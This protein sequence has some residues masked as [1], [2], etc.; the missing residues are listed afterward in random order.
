MRK[1]RCT[2]VVHS[3]EAEDSIRR[4]F[5]E[6]LLGPAQFR[7]S[8][9]PISFE[10]ED[11]SPEFDR[12]AIP[13][14]QKELQHFRTMPDGNELQ[15]ET[16]LNFVHFARRTLHHEHGHTPNNGSAIDGPPSE[17]NYDDSDFDEILYGKLSYGRISH[18]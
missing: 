18:S 15:I 4:V 14:F 13:N 7:R 8:D 10:K 1:R 11:F 16:L 3:D 6:T 5:G 17:V 9:D 12:N 2:L